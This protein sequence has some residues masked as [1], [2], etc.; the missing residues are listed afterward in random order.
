MSHTT[1]ICNDCAIINLTPIPTP[2]AAVKEMRLVPLI[3]MMVT[4]VASYVHSEVPVS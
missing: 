2:L 1:S 4:D 3:S